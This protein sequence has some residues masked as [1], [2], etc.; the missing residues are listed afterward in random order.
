MIKYKPVHKVKASTVKNT[1]SIYHQL[2]TLVIRLVPADRFLYNAPF[3][4]RSDEKIH[5]QRQKCPAI[6]HVCAA[7]PVRARDV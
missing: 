1:L 6:I 3:L 4:V 2:Q 5:T 7:V